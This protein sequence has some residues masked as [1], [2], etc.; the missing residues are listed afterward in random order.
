MALKLPLH[1]RDSRESSSH[2]QG[3]RRERTWLNTNGMGA[4]SAQGT[5]K[6]SME[7]SPAWSVG[8]S[9]WEAGSR[10]TVTPAGQ[11]A[12][13]TAPLPNPGSIPW[14]LSAHFLLE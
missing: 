13:P 3:R 8:T 10:D 4:D 9:G 6:S 11:V 2:E 12:A 1:L 5:F 14:W 7:A